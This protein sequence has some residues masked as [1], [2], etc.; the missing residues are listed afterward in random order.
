MVLLLYHSKKDSNIYLNQPPSSE[1]GVRVSELELIKLK[2]GE[3]QIDLV[4][5]R[6][7][8]KGLQK[9]TIRVVTIAIKG[10]QQIG[11]LTIRSNLKKLTLN[12]Q[13]YILTVLC[14]C[15]IISAP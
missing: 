7:I 4:Y 6:K 1:F 11:K 13:L 12:S 3:K 14:L 2:R 15:D 9:Q 8:P 5:L 10:K